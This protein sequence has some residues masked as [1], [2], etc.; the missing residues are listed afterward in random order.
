MSRVIGL[1][2]CGFTLTACSASVPSLDFLK[3]SI[4]GQSWCRSAQ[5]QK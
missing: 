3:S 5:E 4:F 1:I 2:A